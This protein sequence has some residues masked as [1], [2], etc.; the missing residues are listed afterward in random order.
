[1][2]RIQQTKQR[3]G[4]CCCSQ[5][6]WIV[7]WNT[8]CTT[9][10]LYPNRI[11]SKRHIA[12]RRP[13][14]GWISQWKIGFYFVN[15][16][17]GIDNQHVLMHQDHND[18][19]VEETSWYK[20]RQ[21]SFV[22][23]VHN[24]NDINHGH[25]I[26]TVRRMSKQL[27]FST[28]TTNTHNRLQL[29][30]EAGRIFSIT[31]TRMV[32]NIDLPEVV[33]LY[34]NNVCLT[35]YD[36]FELALDRTTIEQ[37]QLLR[38]GLIPFIQDCIDIDTAVVI[39]HDPIGDAPIH[40][41]PSRSDVDGEFSSRECKGTEQFDNGFTDRKHQ[42]LHM[43][44][45]LPQKCLFYEQTVNPPNPK[46]IMNII[47]TIVIQPRPYGGSSGFGKK[48][49]DP[50]RHPQCQ[51]TVIIGTT[52]QHSRVAQYCGTRSLSYDPN[53]SI[54][55]AVLYDN[56]IDFTVDDIATP[57]SYW[58]N[59]PHPRDDNCNSVDPYDI[60]K[61]YSNRQQQQSIPS[62]SLSSDSL[63]VPI[64]TNIRSVSNSDEDDMDFAA[65]L[66]DLAPL[67]K[68]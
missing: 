19:I 44:N 31:Q 27:P 53:D 6:F 59:P 17:I 49:P 67:A 42:L 68:K 18:R 40:D 7:L 4:K 9:L 43:K 54:A 35:Q 16:H 23:S 20:S 57:G 32:R 58:L 41:H 29:V 25:T 39:L 1:M 22:F 5:Y 63:E 45:Q 47:D 66:A 11:I 26:S 12:R 36:G 64:Q 33:I 55:D 51:Y 24:N 21:L 62:S 38:P 15:R 14:F 56:V 50:P 46:D 60:I 34:G 10:F 65:I 52:E 30:K 3:M 61:Y 2:I 48:L 28:T 8:I 13:Y 37:R